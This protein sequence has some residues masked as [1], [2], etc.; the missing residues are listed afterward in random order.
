ML[1]DNTVSASDD[2]LRILEQVM[3]VQQRSGLDMPLLVDENIHYRVLRL[4]YG[5]PFQKYDVHRYLRRLPLLFGI[6][7]AY[8]H[9]VTVLYRVFFPVLG[10]LECTGEPPDSGDV[11]LV[12][13]VLFME[14]M[15][16]ALLL[17]ARDVVDRLEAKLAVLR[18]QHPGPGPGGEPAVTGSRLLL[19]GLH[20]LLTC[21]LPAALSI[22]YKVRSC[23]WEGRPGGAATGQ[24]ARTVL[25]HCLAVQS[26]V[27]QDWDAK[28]EYTRTISLA[29]LTWTPWMSRLP[30]CCF[31]EEVGEAMLSRLTARCRGNPASSTFSGAFDL[32]A[33]LPQADRGE[34]ATRGTVRPQLVQVMTS[35]MRRLVDDPSS[36]PY[37]KVLSAT[38]AAWQQSWP[39]E[40]AM[41]SSLPSELSEDSLQRVLRGALVVLTR[42]PVTTTAAVL[43]LLDDKV[44][45]A[46][47][48]DIRKRQAW[49]DNRVNTWRTERDARAAQSRVRRPRPPRGGA[50]QDTAV[51]S[52]PA[53]GNPP[54]GSPTSGPP[55]TRETP[56][57]VN[58]SQGSLY[59]PAD[60]APPSDGYVSEGQSSGLG[61]M[62]DLVD[63]SQQDL[64]DYM[65]HYEADA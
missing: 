39:L 47:D 49:I 26:H 30:G 57:D 20:S 17:A 19:E 43:Q 21:Y 44:P 24:M 28:E 58:S 35:R 54:P 38:K 36:V 31:V 40:G 2:L 62:G 29:L 42:A 8:K 6:W 61:S 27:L 1:S 13:K 60:V 10:V 33:S 52:Q 7:H 48:E 16:A 59:D 41:P 65:A 32:F 11:K 3:E 9:T 56:M 18:R 46:R 45:L 22:G 34:K 51:S 25:Q 64:G 23:Y 55:A 53:H 63:V 14:K 50:G 5:R 4:L 12:R 37:A 15:F